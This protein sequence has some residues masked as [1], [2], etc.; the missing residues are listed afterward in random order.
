[1][2][3][4]KDFNPEGLRFAE[5][6]GE[7]FSASLSLTC[8]SAI[9]IR[10]YL[11]SNY[12]RAMDGSSPTLPLE[13][14]NCFADLEK[15]YGPFAYGQVKMSGPILY[16]IG[17]LYRYFCFTYG[18]S[19]AQAYKLIKPA[20]LERVYYPYHSLDPALALEKMLEQRGL[21]GR[22]DLNKKGLMLLK[23]QRK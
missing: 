21:F 15:E 7:I 9:F 13:S 2:Q 19:S 23:K 22:E 6:Q 16:W 14:D 17:Y 1:M 10:R 20:E 12:A 18:I 8:S 11:N 5:K 3:P 4:A